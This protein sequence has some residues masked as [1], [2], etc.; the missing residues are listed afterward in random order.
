MS[1]YR[2]KNSTNSIFLRIVWDLA[3]LVIAF[4]FPWW[5]SVSMIVFAMMSVPRY[6]E[7][8]AVGIM[9]DLV[10]FGGHGW[11]G[12]VVGPGIL[13]LVSFMII[14]LFRTQFRIPEHQ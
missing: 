9:V 6:Y 4:L 1:K 13:V 12:T 10:Y 11:F 7:A 2:E 14:E 8:V 5:F 3:L